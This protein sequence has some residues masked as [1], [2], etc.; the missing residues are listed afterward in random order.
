MS[1]PTA[2]KAE[3]KPRKLRTATLK[4]GHYTILQSPRGLYG[5]CELPEEENHLSMW[6]LSQK[7]QLG[8]ATVLEE[9]MHASRIP[10]RYVHDPEVMIP[11]IRLVW[12][13]LQQAEEPEKED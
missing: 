1:K 4:A 5:C 13:W 11:L 7:T 6:I 12:R 9:G 8:L 10:D 3:N 2:A